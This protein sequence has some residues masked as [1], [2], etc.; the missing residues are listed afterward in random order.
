[1]TRGSRGGSAISPIGGVKLTRCVNWNER[2]ADSARLAILLN[3][4]TVEIFCRPSYP[5]FALDVPA[6]RTYQLVCCQSLWD[7]GMSTDQVPCRTQRTL[8]R[9][10]HVTYEVTWKADS[11]T[12]SV[13]LH[14]RRPSHGR[15]KQA[16]ERRPAGRHPCAQPVVVR[17]TI[18][19][20]AGPWLRPLRKGPWRGW[21]I[22]CDLDKVTLKDVH[23]ALGNPR[24]I[25]IGINLENTLLVVEQAVNRLADLSV[26]RCRDIAGRPARRRNPRRTRCGLPPSCRD[27]SWRPSPEEDRHVR[28]HHC[29]RQL[30]RPVVAA[31]QL[32]R[33]R[34]KILVIDEGE[35]RNRFAAHCNMVSSARTGV[36]PADRRRQGARQLLAYPNVTWLADPCRKRRAAGRWLRGDRQGRCPASSPHHRAR[37]RRKHGLPALPGLAERWGR[38]V[39][40]CPYCHGDPA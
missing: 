13:T 18:G 10:F 19:G 8:H 40:H 1:M 31:L 30:C 38:A 28:C 20:P 7:M 9:R 14:V 25:A 36:D 12:T 26:P 6:E 33:A 16:D 11:R 15:A 24:L 37:D 22:A 5:P 2:G 21:E 23:E 35:R 29:R 17:R 39:F 32:A 34:R 4:S 27:P 3:H